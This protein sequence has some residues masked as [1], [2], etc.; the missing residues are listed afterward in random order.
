MKKIC[1]AV[2]AVA[3]AFSA[4]SCSSTKAAE[5]SAGKS[6]KPAKAAKVSK[7]QQ[8]INKSFNK[9]YNSYANALVLDGAEEYT[10]A[11][12]DT[13]TSI[14]K[15]SYGE[16]NG[17]YFP[18]ILLASRDAVQDPELIQPGTKLLIPSFDANIKDKAVAKKLSPFFK[19]IA[20]VY[21]QKKSKKSEDIRPNLL[22][23]S[24][25]LAADEPAAEAP[26]EA[27]AETPAEA[28]PAE[29]AAPAAEEAAP[30]PA[31]AAK[32]E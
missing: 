22:S 4:L 12:G 25:Q 18:L 24:E 6:T 13:L 28:T 30:A 3:I 17:Y 20:G 7:E 23:I 26:A 11:T 15:K 14:A 31:E 2:L 1:L 16:D 9:V 8:A 21:E 19:D 5:D 10:V 32:A 29:G 27:T